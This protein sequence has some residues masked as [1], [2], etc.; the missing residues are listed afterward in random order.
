[1]PPTQVLKSFI[2]II[3]IIKSGN[4]GVRLEAQIDREERRFGVLDGLRSIIARKINEIH[5]LRRS[6]IIKHYH[7]TMIR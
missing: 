2:L 7:P 5:N 4:V 6:K 3:E 1:M